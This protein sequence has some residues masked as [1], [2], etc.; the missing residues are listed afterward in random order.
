MNDAF[1]EL[2]GM[3]A[4]IFVGLAESTEPPVCAV[5]VPR[6]AERYAATARIELPGRVISA[7]GKT[8]GRF[9]ATLLAGDIV[10][11]EAVSTRWPRALLV[12]DATPLSSDGGGAPSAQH[13]FVADFEA[14][15][16]RFD[17]LSP[18]A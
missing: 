15:E 13:R 18:S 17:L 16:Q 6:V 9:T 1:A 8:A 10:R 5:R 11:V 12:L 4:E 2:L 7:D 3:F 14:L